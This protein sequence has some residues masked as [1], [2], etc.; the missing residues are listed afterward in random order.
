[1]TAGDSGGEVPPWQDLR[2]S[3]PPDPPEPASPALAGQTLAGQTLAGRAMAGRALAGRA[4]ARRRLALTGQRSE[5]DPPPLEPG[6]A[7]VEPG[8]AQLGAGAARRPGS[9]LAQLEPGL[10]ELEAVPA[11]RRGSGLAELEPGPAR[12]LEPGLAQ[13]PERGL[14][15]RPERGPALSAPPAATHSATRQRRGW[16]VPFA[17][18]ALT[19]V[20]L[21]AAVAGSVALL[22]HQHAP[23]KPAKPRAAQAVPM[24]ARMPSTALFQALT[25]DIQT[26][27]EAAFLSQ[28]APAARPAV[29]TW[30]QNLQAIGFTSGAIMPAASSDLLPVDSRGDGTI[31]V[32]AGTHSQLDPVGGSGQP[33]IP[34]ERYQLGLHFA[35]AGA[36]G[37]ITSWQ[38]LGDD[39]WDQGGQLYV[40]QAAD[41]V[42]AG[43]ADDSAVVDQTLPIA[44]AAASYDIGLLDHVDRGDLH[45]AGFVVF[46]SGSSAVS[47]D[48]FRTSWL[49]QSWPPES[50]GGV[51]VPLSSATGGS[52]A[53]GGARVV[54]TPYADD[55]GTAGS[56]TAQLVR[57]FMLDVLASDDQA[58]ASPVPSWAI[59]GFG[60]AV[61]ALYQQSTSPAKASYNVKALSSQ[62]HG[63][64]SSYRT[65]Q[66][67]TSQQLFVGNATA[68][69]DFGDIAASVYEYIG[70]KYGLNQMFNAAALLYARNDTPFSNVQ[71]PAT[72]RTASFYPSPAIESAWHAWLAR[73]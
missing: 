52:A 26:Q 61:Q 43:P 9:G 63:L 41:V 32:L 31:T 37:Q 58:L 51:T 72:E 10:A 5:L 50:G 33:D 4:L 12:Q 59:Q 38:P 42:V 70:I 57:Q 62:L 28:V 29:Q 14:A 34:S 25:Q 20:V 47:D 19:V 65:G 69:Q 60:L 2:D 68:E 27:N 15:Q 55:G 11:R 49:P 36:M 30:W 17:S 73:T 6:L 40:R 46:V 54:I 3:P 16:L 56:E 18:G 45:Q 21:A 23:R 53:I 24:P 7:Q 44:E 66:L 48:W 1:M 67:P 71:A 13:R 39:P 8:L 22:H 64:R 35:S